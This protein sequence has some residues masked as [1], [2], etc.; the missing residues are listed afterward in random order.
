MGSKED[1]KKERQRILNL[2]KKF[3]KRITIARHGREAFLAKQYVQCMQKYIEYLTIMADTK[4][5]SDIYTLSPSHFDDTTQLSELLLISH[6]YWEM[7]RINEMT[8]KL[9]INFQKCLS[10]FVKF[11]ANQPY[12]VLNAE[13]LRKYN[14]LHGKRSRFA[15]KYSEAYSEIFVQSKKC[16]IATECFGIDHLHTNNLRSF[17]QE[18]LQWPFGELLVA[19]YY[20]SSPLMIKKMRKY[21]LLQITK[22]YLFIPIL[23][24]FSLFTETSIFKRCSYYLKLLQ[25]NGSSRS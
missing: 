2:E 6:V 23:T 22:N 11:T 25:K 7:A 13:M 18:L 8:P 19:W 21:K 5:V 4:G 12:Q 9:Q 3:S 24:F 15:A 14:K 16:F 10:Q 20:K 17:K 1:D